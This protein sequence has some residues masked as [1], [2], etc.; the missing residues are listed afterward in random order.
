MLASVA[1][2]LMAAFTGLS[3]TRGA[4]AQPVQQRKLLTVMSAIVLGGGIWSMHFVAMLGLQLPY[5]FFYDALVT[6]GSALIAILMMGLALLILHFGPRTQRR[7]V[8]A[9]TIV[10][11]G[12][13]LMHFIGMLGMQ[14]CRPVNGA[15]D[16][17][18]STL[19]SLGLS[20]LAITIAYGRRTR[21]N[22]LLG[23]ICF[24]L[25]VVAVHYVA[26]FQTGFVLVEEAAAAAG[27]VL[28]NKVLA[29]G[30]TVA[31]FMICGSF[32]LTGVTFFEPRGVGAMTGGGAAP[33]AEDARAAP[34]PEPAAPAG[35]PF[36]R[37]GRTQFAPR[38]DIAA[39]R[40]EGHYTVLYLEGQ[41]L[42]CPWSITE[43]AER[44]DDAGFIRVHRSYLVNPAH[45]AEFTR[46]KD[47]GTVRFFGGSAEVRVPVSRSR[48]GEVREALGL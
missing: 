26:V 12:I 41:K 1:V 31:A 7:I 34:P 8:L 37:D 20:I 47:T 18:L 28:G 35:V 38:A 40:A 5:P 17:V 32:L 24:G 4:S 25:A 45:V 23:T 33:A 2:S 48:L 14:V 9:G 16:Y 11:L 36:E 43:A 22:I 42:F 46:Q 19:A 27:P 21:A 44:L 6:L 3:L 15:G 39:I 29:M 30:V 10:G 13:V